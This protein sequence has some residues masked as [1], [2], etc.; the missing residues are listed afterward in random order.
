MSSSRDRERMVRREVGDGQFIV[1][2]K[3][4]AGSFG[5]VYI[6]ISQDSG[7]EVAI[8]LESTSSKH[9]QL[10]YEM[11]ILKELQGEVGVAELFYYG[12]ERYFSVLVISLLGNSLEDLFNHCKRRFT[13]VCVML[14]GEQL[15]DRIE[16]MHSK[17]FIHRDIKPD[18]FLIGRGEER[19]LIYIIDFGLSKKYFYPNKGRHI[20][21]KEGKNL[22][23]TPRYA[24]VNNHHGYEQSRRDDIESIGYVLTYFARGK[25]PW[26]GLKAANKKDKYRKIM[27]KKE[28]VRLM[29]RVR[30]G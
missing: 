3:I 27:Q 2:E 8:K 21:W 9:P 26:Q 7:R 1:R 25:L 28:K 15:I 23:G 5:D 6:G 10:R 24:S 4:G 19:N 16:Y 17:N 11:K 13:P 22:T 12:V 14:L 29:E 20:P 18:N 30:E